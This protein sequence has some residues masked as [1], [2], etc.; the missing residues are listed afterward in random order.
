MFIEDM[1]VGMKV[2][3]QT[4]TIKNEMRAATHSITWRRALL[5]GQNFLFIVK[6][7]SAEGRALC[8]I[9]NSLGGDYFMEYDLE[10]LDESS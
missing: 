5:V 2:V 3:P 9:T 10:P 6:I 1:S 4:R 7:D 8:N